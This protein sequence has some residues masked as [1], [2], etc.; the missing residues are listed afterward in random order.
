MR[1]IKKIDFNKRKFIK[2]FMQFSAEHNH[3]DPYE[4]WYRIIA[5]PCELTTEENLAR[6]VWKGIDAQTREYER[7]IDELL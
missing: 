5:F 4:N 2:A 3:G 7:T 6:L 1:F